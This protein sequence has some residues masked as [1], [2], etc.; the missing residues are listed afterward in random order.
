MMMNASPGAQLIATPS[1]PPGRLTII[2]L[3]F[4]VRVDVEHVLLG[5]AMFVPLL[6]TVAV[7]AAIVAVMCILDEIEG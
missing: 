5:C 3:V 2:P 7:D 6:L 1:D 4:L